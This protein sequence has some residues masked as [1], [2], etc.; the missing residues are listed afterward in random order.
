MALRM[1][2]QS[3]HHSH[4]FL[5][6]YYRRMRAK[7]GTPKAITAAAH[8]LARIVF[9]LLTTRE[10]YNETTFARNEELHQ[11]RLES[12][13]RKQARQLGFEIVLATPGPK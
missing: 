13:L 10:P 11:T 8:K 6:E 7:L 4:S 5:G 1:A 12:K 3:L 2:A 9:H